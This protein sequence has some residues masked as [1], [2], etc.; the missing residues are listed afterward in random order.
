MEETALVD[1]LATA[2][3]PV[4]GELVDDAGFLELLAPLERDGIVARTPGPHGRPVYSL[5]RALAEHVRQTRPPERRATA[6]R[7]LVAVLAATTGSPRQYVPMHA[8][9]RTLRRRLVALEPVLVRAIALAQ[10]HELTA[11]AADIALFL[12]EL[13]YAVQGN[14]PPPGRI[15]WL[16]ARDD[17]D[18]A[19][20]ID[21]LVTEATTAVGHHQVEDARRLL[22]D[23]ISLARERGDAGRIA[24]ALAQRAMAQLLLTTDLGS[25]VE[26]ERE[27]V[28]LAEST[29]DPVVVAGTLCVLYPTESTPADLADT[30]A[31]SLAAARSRDH[32]GLVMMALANLAMADLDHGRPDEAAV[33]A[34][35]CAALAADLQHRG[36]VPIMLDIAQ[37][38][39]L[40]S[41]NRSSVR[42]IAESVAQAACNRD[43]RLLSEGLLRF[44]AG[45]HRTGRS[46]DA[47][48][49]RGLYD[50]LLI[51]AGA[52]TTTSEAEFAARWL[53]EVRAVA[54][55]EPA[56]DGALRL[57]REVE[58]AVPVPSAN[59][60]RSSPS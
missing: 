9:D 54:A 13:H 5:V 34:R 18:P 50:A 11:E 51:E 29:R 26:A 27:A 40:L 58:G 24:V 33:H 14:P 46:D 49:A 53:G 4:D 23:A 31:R 17:L 55:Q 47:A 25:D 32:V 30:L 16:L 28:R 10:E 37:T 39:E 35:E 1:L 42:R 19:R 6:A 52:G 21:L 43:L 12:P 7:R 41:G 8:S 44:A 45:L 36:L 22:G 48:R 56:Y 38:G 60:Q 2:V 20:R 59:L 3:D 15:D 57:A